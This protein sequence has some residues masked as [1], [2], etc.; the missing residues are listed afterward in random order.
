M[1]L[2]LHDFY[3][4]PLRMELPWPATTTPRCALI[5][6]SRLKSAT[7][8]AVM[9]STGLLLRVLRVRNPFSV[10]WTQDPMYDFVN[11]QPLSGVL[12][13]HS[14]YEVVTYR[15][16]V[17]AVP[18]C[19]VDRYWFELVGRCGLRE[20]HRGLRHFRGEH[21]QSV[22]QDAV[23]KHRYISDSPNPL[24]RAKKECLRWVA[25]ST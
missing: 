13:G 25:L 22:G 12:P 23:S 2:F 16:Y 8:T 5:P 17:L 10:K 9:S 24:S 6:R 3:A 1:Y 15:G 14:S 11:N 19:E 18:L 7:C 4:D 21:V 20:R